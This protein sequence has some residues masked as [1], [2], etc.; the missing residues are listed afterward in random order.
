MGDYRK[1]FK[2]VMF[3][4]DWTCVYCGK[5]DTDL[6]IDH[7]IPQILGGPDV[8]QNLV[9]ACTPCNS[10]KQGHAPYEV[11]MV[12]RYGRFAERI[13]PNSSLIA[14]AV[15]ALLTD[16]TDIPTIA[17]NLANHGA[18]P[19]KLGEDYLIS[20]NGKSAKVSR[21]FI[22]Y[23]CGLYA[24]KNF[25]IATLA[26]LDIKIAKPNTPKLSQPSR[27][28]HIK[29]KILNK[30]LRELTEQERNDFYRQRASM[31]RQAMLAKREAEV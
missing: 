31:G 10:R 13:S 29:L 22:L 12:A 4:D 21:E 19:S 17:S 25:Q 20:L 26:N 27:Q 28:R 14:Q 18:V 9:A 6:A 24:G 3:L 5:W 7:Y 1:F 23:F 2:E 15:N 8:I 11:N 16:F 30:P